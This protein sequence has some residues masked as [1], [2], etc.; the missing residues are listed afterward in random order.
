MRRSANSG[1]SRR[2]CLIESQPPHNGH[3]SG[4]SNPACSLAVGVIIAA[5]R[6]TLESGREARAL[7]GAIEQVPQC[8]ESCRHS[9]LEDCRR[10]V[11]SCTQDCKAHSMVSA[12]EVLKI[13]KKSG[14]PSPRFFCTSPLGCVVNPTL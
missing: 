9:S 13:W 6:Y 10:T 3:L 1:H 11:C 12:K 8:G 14:G 4:S 7:V 5:V 2:R